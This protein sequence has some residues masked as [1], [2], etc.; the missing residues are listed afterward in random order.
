MYGIEVPDQIPDKGPFPQSPVAWP[1][2]A[3]VNKHSPAYALEEAAQTFKQRAEVYGDNYKI[4]GDVMM[5]LF[6]D[7]NVTLSCKEDHNRFGLLVQIV[8]KLTRYAENFSKGGHDD[9]L[10]DLSVYAAMLRS[11]DKEINEVPF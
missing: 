2:T 11:L 4:Y 9:S 10:N 6:A 1:E 8:S 7:K 5:M 3:N